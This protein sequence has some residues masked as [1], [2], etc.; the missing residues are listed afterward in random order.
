MLRT[1]NSL[2]MKKPNSQLLM[3]FNTKIADK[4]LFS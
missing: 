3:K 1:G 2:K 4:L